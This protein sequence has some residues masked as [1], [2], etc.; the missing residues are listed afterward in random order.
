M[1]YLW[2]PWR[3]QYVTSA[4]TPDRC[5]LCAAAESTNDRETL[6]VY[7]G[8]TTF[9]I[10]NRFPYTNGHVM[11]VPY[12]HVANLQDLSDETL[13]EMTRLAKTTERHL[14]QLYHPDGLNIGMNLGK[15]AGAGIEEHLHLHALPRW[16]GDTNFMTVVGETRVMPEDLAV[17]W[18]RLREAFDGDR[19]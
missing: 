19:G 10:L 18:T 2:T 13:I 9:V 16:S 1:D 3:Y 15:S 17:T 7:R 4:G 11:I 6:V 14:R 8:Q 12:R 5:V